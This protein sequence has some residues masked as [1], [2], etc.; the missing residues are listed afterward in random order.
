MKTKIKTGWEKEFEEFN[1]QWE[2]EFDKLVKRGL[3]FGVF[4][5]SRIKS[6]IR[7]LLA[8]ERKKL[9]RDF[10]AGLEASLFQQKQELK[11]KVE[12]V[13]GLNTRPVFINKAEVIKLLEEGGEKNENK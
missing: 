9:I 2:K 7:T 11:K 3:E 10:R 12:G 5:Y 4:D 13:T 8:Q 1:K 6:F